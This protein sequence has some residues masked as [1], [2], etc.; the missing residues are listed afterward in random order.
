MK[1][2]AKVQTVKA[3][4]G[5]KVT[6]SVR[7]F[8]LICDEPVESGGTNTGMN[9]VEALLSALGSCL[10]IAAYYLAESQGVK[11]E[12]FGMDLEGDV[13]PDGFMGVNPDAR[14]GFSEIRITPHIK[15]DAD[16]EK[17]REFVK[18][19]KSRCPVSDNVANP[20]PIVMSD[21]V[22]EH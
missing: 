16:D 11:V 20:T 1:S 22:V 12:S 14:N 9:P 2:T 15:C 4:E 10:T 18:F 7:G 21:I 17:A 6:S 5:L 3:P 19:V 8:E 13:D